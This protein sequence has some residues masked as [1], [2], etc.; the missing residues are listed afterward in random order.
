MKSAR[1]LTLTAGAAITKEAPKLST[2]PKG[3]A[4]AI[5]HDAKVFSTTANK[6]SNPAIKKKANAVGAQLTLFAADITA[7]AKSPT[8]ANYTTLQAELT[9]LQ[10]AL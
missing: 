9:P 10:N 6:L 8:T 4:A 7:L 1:I 3:A 5:T 2:D